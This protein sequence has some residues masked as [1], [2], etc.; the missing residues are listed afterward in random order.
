MEPKLRRDLKL[1]WINQPRT[2]NRCPKC[3]VGFLDTRTHRSL[4]AKTF[5]FWKEIKRYKC[6]NCDARVYVNKNN[7]LPRRSLL[8]DQHNDYSFITAKFSRQ[9]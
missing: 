1:D 7:K 8:F 3:K 4:F 6:N 9:H 5:L 2:Y